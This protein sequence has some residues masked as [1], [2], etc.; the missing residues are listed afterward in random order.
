MAQKS[1]RGGGRL[2]SAPTQ[3]EL[4]PTGFKASL[5]FQAL[6][7][8]S[9]ILQQLKICRSHNLIATD[10]CGVAPSSARWQGV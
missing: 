10:I 7:L 6:H 5:H 9:S 8:S 2:E 1:W 3:A 4:D